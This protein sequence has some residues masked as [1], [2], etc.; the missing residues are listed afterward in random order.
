MQFRYFTP[1]DILKPYV[2]HYY[3]FDSSSADAFEDTVFPSG[4]MEMIFNLGEGSWEA[5]MNDRYVK[6]PAIELWGQVTKPMA[7]KSTGR[8]TM[9]GV[10]F[11][12]HA[13]SLFL[14]DGINIYNDQVSDLH[15]IIGNPIKKLHAQLLETTDTDKRIEQVETFLIKKVLANEKKQTKIAKVAHIL[16]SIKKNT[17]EIDFGRI[18]NVHGITPRYLRK[19]IYQH[20]GLSPTSFNK[21]SRFQYS[22]K[23]IVKNNQPSFTSIAY[24]C[25]Y[26]DQSHFIRDFKAFAGVTPSAYLKNITP[27]NQLLLQ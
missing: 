7:I 24:E 12:T 15:A 22:L 5:L 16:T 26:F 14:Q 25:G 21:I 1:C 19:L 2:K 8:H 27:V 11:F 13:A 23:L 4:D 3:I 17:D 6:N 18:A 10:K 20:T 9:L